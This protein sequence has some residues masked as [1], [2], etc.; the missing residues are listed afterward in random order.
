[1]Q[2]RI[3]QTNHH[4]QAIHR[5]EGGFDILFDK[6]KQFIESFL[7]LFQRTG[8]NHL[9]QEEQ[10]LFTV[11]AVEHM[12]RAEQTN[13]FGSKLTGPKS[14]FR[15]IGIGTDTQFPHFIAQ[16][17]KT[18]QNLVLFAD[19]HHRQFSKIHESLGS[20]EGNPVSFLNDS[21][22]HKNLLF[23][24]L[25]LQGSAADNAAFAP[26]AGHQSRMAGHPAAGC[27]NGL[28]CTHAFHIFR[29]GLFADQNHGFA[30]RG[31]GH[32]IRRGKDNLSRR[33][34]RPGRKT[35]GQHFL[36]LFHLRIDNRMKQ[37]IQLSRCHP[38][39]RFFRCNQFLLDHI[40]RHPH[41]RR[42]VPLANTALEDKQ[43]AP[44]NG[45]LDVLHIPIVLLQ[46]VF[47]VNQFLI[48]FGH[49][50]LE[51]YQMFIVFRLRVGVDGG[52]CANT[53]HHIFPLSIDQIFTVKLV[54]TIARIAGKGH[55]GSGVFSH[56]TEDHGLDVDR[57][58]PVVRNTLNPPIA[59]RP[60][61]VPGGKHRTNRTPQ[62]GIGFIRKFLAKYLLHFLF[63]LPAKLF[64]VLYGQI[65][66]RLTA[67]SLLHLVHNLFQ[68]TANPLIVFRLNPGGLFH[69]H[70]GVH[71]N[72]PAIGVI[73]EPFVAALGDH[74]R[75]R[76]GRQTHIENRFHHPRHRGAGTGANRHKQRIS[77]VAELAAHNLLHF[78]QRLL[79]LLLKPFGELA[80]VLVVICAYFCCNGE[81]RGYRYSQ[82]G[83]F[84]QI[85]S[86]ASQQLFHLRVAVGCAAAEEIHHPGGTLCFRFAGGRFSFCGTL[87]CRC[88]C[89]C[90][91]LS[92]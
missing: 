74:S 72:Q 42:P 10:R 16:R 36:L 90:H 4:R 27:Q 73:N 62:L 37:F 28:S 17:Q 59:D 50:L 26:A 71:H 57:C 53:C 6:R 1:M 55:T 66:I 39:H 21:P 35:L 44:L 41:G 5:F 81:T 87:F 31:P 61:A 91:R 83:H 64:Q 11:L 45:E 78:G 82:P 15:R 51:R 25:N 70:I 79:N 54:F 68:L 67:A 24:G 60:L 86:L 20:V 63:E 29:T 69:H 33:R 46:Q 12:F 32:S 7:P 30:L 89:L 84:R 85:S 75:N 9:S 92:P 13:T 34:A 40:D 23:G 88:L 56:I 76:C 22:V 58:T 43:P 65:R 3:Q 8:H 80:V 47:N 14:I 49:R 77:G 48:Q 18:H 52:R 38:H 19:I 2:R